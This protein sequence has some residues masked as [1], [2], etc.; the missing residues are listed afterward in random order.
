M[1]NKKPITYFLTLIF[2][3]TFI[4]FGSGCKNIKNIYGKYLGTIDSNG[5]ITDVVIFVSDSTILED[6]LV[7]ISINEMDTSLPPHQ[8]KIKLTNDNEIELIFD[9]HNHL[10]KVKS[11][12]SCFQSENKKAEFHLCLNKKNIT[13]TFTS[14]ENGKSSSIKILAKKSDNFGQFNIK[15][16]Y[17]I[18]EL[19]ARTKFLNYNVSS[20][21][22]SLYQARLKISNALGNLIPHLSL[23][24]IWSLSTEG[25][26]AIIGAVGNLVPFIFPSNWYEFK[27][28]ENVY[29]AERNSYASLRGNEM[30]AL[31]GMVYFHL[32]NL[33]LLDKLKK[34]KNW[35]DKLLKSL[36]QMREAQAIPLDI[37][38]QLELEIAN[39]EFDI[40]QIDELT[41][42]EKTSILQAVSL[43]TISSINVSS[44]NLPKINE[45]LILNPHT[46]CTSDFVKYSYEIKVFD[47]LILAAKNAVKTKQY[48]FL[49]PSSGE[50]NFSI[51]SNIKIS[52]SNVKDLEIKKSELESLLLKRCF[53]TVQERNNIIVTYKKSYAH[54][55]T[56]NKMQDIIFKKI[57]L[58]GHIKKDT[59]IDI[60]SIGNEILKIDARIVNLTGQYM[61]NDSKLNRLLLKSSYSSLGVG[62]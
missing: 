59:I 4:L 47:D 7:D 44:P 30:N 52:K 42:S 56:A 60:I 9:N 55:Q 38:T 34:Q 36:I 48:S 29:S 17:K 32:K 28:S 10:F 22:Q 49:D 23:S 18:E 40:R 5:K 2:S 46:T 41:I 51:P 26:L 27:E 21:A 58:E 25:P 1:I 12:S 11:I 15:S 62:L 61:I 20:K 54:W 35:L 33:S 6:K 45:S 50:L 3:L 19:M 24:D 37:L 53:D 43:P 16:E 57:F 31:E 39:Y 8:L 13:F 14:Y